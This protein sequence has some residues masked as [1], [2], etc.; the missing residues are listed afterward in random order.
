[1]DALTGTKNRNAMNNRVDE[2][3]N[4][5]FIFPKSIG[6]VFADLNGLKQTNDIF[7]KEGLRSQLLHALNIVF[8]DECGRLELSGAS[9]FARPPKVFEDIIYRLFNVDIEKL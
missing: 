7:R 6:V 8:P 5:H 1:M 4:P 3:D 2:F 9:F